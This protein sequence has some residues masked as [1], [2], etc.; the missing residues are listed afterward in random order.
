M[1]NYAVSVY[2][3]NK[4]VVFLKK[5]VRGGADKSYGIEVAKL[6]GIPSPIIQLAR[7]YLSQLESD[8]PATPSINTA[9][10]PSLW[11]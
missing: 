3:N 10:T 7:G 8:M 2:E 6:A 5:V 1:V 9:T 11:E 4:E